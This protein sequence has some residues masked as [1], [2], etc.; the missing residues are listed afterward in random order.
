MRRTVFARSTPLLALALALAGCDGAAP[1]QAA[2]G[3]LVVD[4]VGRQ[5]QR[6]VD[7]R[8]SAIY[9]T[10]DSVL[11]VIALDRSWGAGLALRTVFPVPRQET[12][13]LR[14]ALE[15]GPNAVMALR[16]IADSVRS[17]VVLVSGTLTLEPGRDA[18]G[19]FSG[20][21]PRRD[22]TSATQRFVGAFRALPTIDS[23]V[24]CGAGAR[25]P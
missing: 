3:H 17:A 23:A 13:P 24:A 16:G 14:L 6:L 7:V 10:V 4:R 18:S 19:A 2:R 15:A 5:H 21:L 1:P 9:C 20:T 12:L 11:V 8:T 25:I 22:S